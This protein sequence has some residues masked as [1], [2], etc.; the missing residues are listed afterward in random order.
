[1]T[2]QRLIIIRHAESLEDIDNNAYEFLTDEEMPLSEA[3]KVQSTNLSTEL[4]SI[5]GEYAPIHFYL[6]PCLRVTETARIVSDAMRN[7]NCTYSIEEMLKKQDW[8]PI[9]M[10]NRKQIERERYEAGVLRYAFRSG[11][12]GPEFIARYERFLNNVKRTLSHESCPENIAII[13]HGF[14]IRV[15]LMILLGWDE[16]YF[17]TLAY[18]NNCEFKRLDIQPDGSFALIDQMRLH[19]LSG[20]PN[21]IPRK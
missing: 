13:S 4:R 2:A 17:E 6:A 7:P 21:F 5:I 8:G 1:M 16:D 11:E 15:L 18:P 12:S 20:S 19:N 3:G 10:D 14:E 9:T